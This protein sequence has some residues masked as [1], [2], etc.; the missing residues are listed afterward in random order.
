[1][2]DMLEALPGTFSHTGGRGT[3]VFL[4]AILLPN[5]SIT[6]VVVRLWTSKFIV[7]R[8]YPDDSTSLV[9]RPTWKSMLKLTLA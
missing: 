6:I 8:W 2:S 1:M 5:F 9:S 3:D 7:R 4:T